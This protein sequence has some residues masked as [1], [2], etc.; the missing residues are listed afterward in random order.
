MMTPQE[1]LEEAVLHWG[2]T[3][4]VELTLEVYGQVCS[5]GWGETGDTEGMGKSFELAFAD[6][7]TATELRAEW[8]NSL[9][10]VTWRRKVKELLEVEVLLDHGGFMDI[11]QA[12]LEAERIAGSSPTDIILTLVAHHGGGV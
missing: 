5:V 4:W 2:P 7:P 10:A 11:D 1:A 12:W 3:A 6:T 8:C 9:Q